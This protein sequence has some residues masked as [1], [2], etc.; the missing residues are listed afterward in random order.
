MFSQ[1]SKSV[2]ALICGIS[3][4][5]NVVGVVEMSIQVVGTAT[6]IRLVSSTRNSNPGGSTN[7]PPADVV[8]PPVAR[9]VVVL[10]AP[11]D[12]A[13]ASNGG[14]AAANSN[15]PAP[16]TVSVRLLNI[17]Y[18]LPSLAGC[19]PQELPSTAHGVL[20]VA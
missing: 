15:A 6:V 1:A 8:G 20:M 14:V 3:A 4:S 11:G 13:P 17:A 16:I 18:L 5:P 9:F 12:S 7:S 10:P 2:E 19:R